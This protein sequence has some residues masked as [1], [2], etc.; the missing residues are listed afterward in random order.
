[1]T[2]F[3]TEKD[4]LRERRPPKRKPRIWLR[5]VVGLVVLLLAG[6]GIGWLVYS[7]T[8]QPF[9]NSAGFSGPGTPH[10]IKAIGDG[11]DQTKWLVVGPPGTTAVVEYEVAN[12]GRHAATILGLDRHREPWITAVR[13]S[14]YS[15]SNPGNGSEIGLLT[16]AHDFPVT[17]APHTS[18]MV[19]VTVMKRNCGQHGF[20]LVESVPLRWS[21]LGV[22]HTWDM[23]LSDTEFDKPIALCAPSAA[24][25]HIEH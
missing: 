3:M 1:M 4:L 2:A 15:A 22:H 6:G 18:V 12:N 5:I 21:A 23:S 11:I 19:Q 14:D 25:S 20:L 10:S 13:W 9:D 16:S 7:Y 24:L 17:L 8:Y